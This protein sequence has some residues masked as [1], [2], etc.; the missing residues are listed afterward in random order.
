LTAVILWAISQESSP[1]RIF[2]TDEVQR[3]R[4]LSRYNVLEAPKPSLPGIIIDILYIIIMPI[5][6]RQKRGIGEKIGSK[7]LVEDSR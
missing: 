6:S 4:S 2:H 3:W 5:L 1:F 7:A